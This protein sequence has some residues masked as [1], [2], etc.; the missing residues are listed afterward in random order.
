MRYI[1]TTGIYTVYDLN[2][3]VDIYLFR[4]RMENDIPN[5]QFFGGILEVIIF[6]DLLPNPLV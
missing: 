2:A 5:V 3:F 1:F 4:F 6:P